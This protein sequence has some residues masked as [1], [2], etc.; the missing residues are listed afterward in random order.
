MIANLRPENVP[1]L[2]PIV[3]ELDIR[4][5]DEE[6][7]EILQIIGDVLGREEEGMGDEEGNGE[8]GQAANGHVRDGGEERSEELNGYRGSPEPI[9]AHEGEDEEMEEDR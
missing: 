8:G 7:S 6:Q 4:F 3:E 9:H 5:S 2:L 1:Q